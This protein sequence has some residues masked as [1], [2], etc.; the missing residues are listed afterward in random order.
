MNAPK[1]KTPTGPSGVAAQPYQKIN[2]ITS[3]DA[4]DI[5]SGSSASS[6]S[7]GPIAPG[8][9]VAKKAPKKV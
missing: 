4:A 2:M 6:S 5:R 3:K 1:P 8:P 7:G 9:I